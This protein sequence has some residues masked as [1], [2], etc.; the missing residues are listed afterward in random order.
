MSTTWV[1]LLGSPFQIKFSDIR[2]VT[3]RLLDAGAGV[4]LICLHGIGG[5]LEA[6]SRNIRSHATHFRV[7]APDFIGHGFSDKPDFPYEITTYAEHILDLMDSFGLPKANFSGA[8]LGGWVAAWIAAKFPSKVNKLVLNTA[9]G[10]DID[11]SVMER[12]KSLSMEAVTNP[13]RESVRKRLELI[14]A[15]AASV[16]EELVEIRYQIYSQSGMVRTMENIMCIENIE[17]RRRNLLAPQ[18]LKGIT[19]PTFVI[20]TTRDPIFPVEVG[21]RFTECIPNS[22]LVVI[23]DCGHWP[24]FEKAAEFNRLQLEFLLSG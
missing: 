12:I 16:T 5:H 15:D 22:R 9:G 21:R 20:W 8:S 11:Q 1:Q 18:L 23:E 10:F 3:T 7:L 13:T 14:M 4:P 6:Y 2:G 19:A 24:Q 17:I